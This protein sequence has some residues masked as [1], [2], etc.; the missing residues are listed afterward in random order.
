LSRLLTGTVWL[1][2]FAANAANKQEIPV[3]LKA[4]LPLIELRGADGALLAHNSHVDLGELQLGRTHTV[5]AFH[6]HNTGEV[7]ALVSLASSGTAQLMPKDSRAVNI[8]PGRSHGF[9]LEGRPTAK[10]VRSWSITVG[11]DGLPPVTLSV[12][13]FCGAPELVCNPRVLHFEAD[14]RKEQSMSVPVATARLKVR[15][16]G[17]LPLVVELPA[18]APVRFTAAS[19]G[20]SSNSSSKD[21]GLSLTIPQRGEQ[22][23]VCTLQHE[24]KNKSGEVLLHTNVIDKPSQSVRWDLNVLAPA[25]FISE[26]VIDFGTVSPT[27][28]K[29]KFMAVHNTGNVAAKV[30]VFLGP[31]SISDGG[32]TIKLQPTVLQK[33]KQAVPAGEPSTFMIS[34]SQSMSFAVKL[35]AGGK[36]PLSVHCTLEVHCLNERSITGHTTHSITVQA[37]VGTTTAGS[38]QAGASTPAQAADPSQDSAAVVPATYLCPLPFDTIAH[39]AEQPSGS[40]IAHSLPAA[41]AAILCSDR[42]SP[43][44]MSAACRRLA[45]TAGQDDAAVAC[46]AA[47]LAAGATPPDDAAAA[48]GGL[49]WPPLA[50]AERSKQLLEEFSILDGL[51]DWQQVHSADVFRMLQTVVP[52]GLVD[53]FKAFAA[54]F[55]ESKPLSVALHFALSGLAQ[56]FRSPRQMAAVQHVAAQLKVLALERAPLPLGL[57]FAVLCGSSSS[58]H[59][60]P[61]KASIT[62][63]ET[64]LPEPSPAQPQDGKA[65]RSSMSLAKLLAGIAS[66]PGTPA[67]PAPLL[68][69]ASILHHSPGSQ[70]DPLEL[71]AALLPESVFTAAANICSPAAELVV[72]GAVEAVCMGAPAQSVA[73]ARD[74]V[75]GLELLATSAEQAAKAGAVSSM[76]QAAGVPHGIASSVEGLLSAI[77]GTPTAVSAAVLDAVRGACTNVHRDVADVADAAKLARAVTRVHAFLTGRLAL[78]KFEACGKGVCSVSDLVAVAES[79]LMAK[80][81]PGDKLLKIGQLLVSG[82]GI[83][84]MQ[85]ALFEAASL[86]VTEAGLAHNVAIVQRFSAAVREMGHL[87]AVGRPHSAPEDVMP[88]VCNLS[89]LVTG[90]EAFSVSLLPAA[91]E[92]LGKPGAASGMG[93]VAEVASVL[94]PMPQPSWATVKAL[95]GILQQGPPLDQADLILGASEVIQPSLRDLCSAARCFL[96]SSQQGVADLHAAFGASWGLYKAA[97]DLSSADGEREATEQ[98][99]HDVL[100]ACVDVAAADV[101]SG[102]NERAGRVATA[103]SA[104][105]KWQGLCSSTSS[106]G[107]NEFGASRAGLKTA[108]GAAGD[109]VAQSLALG[110]LGMT[111]A[112]KDVKQLAAMG[113]FAAALAPRAAAVLLVADPKSTEPAGKAAGVHAIMLSCLDIVAVYQLAVACCG[114]HQ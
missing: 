62:F 57:T 43:A 72:Q 54:L 90:S 100:V 19:A 108:E 21:G 7:A 12:G 24:W 98:T 91:L 103:L 85:V 44:A 48:S 27:A 107:V 56:A 51:G 87:L 114:L 11:T 94:L 83:P 36:A 38:R 10:G 58:P 30:A 31:Y 84:G 52:D 47:W 14:S 29:Q 71:L 96:A 55:D 67:M 17:N 66:L 70:A 64:L 16:T 15:N 3:L 106:G 40:I 74:F 9:L 77:E 93:L 32:C 88:A 97:A 95:S 86:C 53:A 111:A 25:L 101:G 59:L 75:C 34:P 33:Q 76:L 79:W 2:V 104:V 60:Q 102:W 65:E 110:A 73:R 68:Q 28:E 39:A 18:D 20:S 50:S 42:R 23:V 37:Q 1:Q 35:A 63:V 92:Y 89:A 112:R 6:A 81:L 41:L 99:L 4:R 82:P 80:S 61:I 46:T 69:A 49:S 13:T 8:A 105:W 109:L 113:V 5:T 22:E 78:A 26:R 45:A